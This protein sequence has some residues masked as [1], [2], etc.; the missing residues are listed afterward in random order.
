MRAGSPDRVSIHRAGALELSAHIFDSA[1]GEVEM[2]CA[3]FVSDNRFA[4]QA[5]RAA[6]F[7]DTEASACAAALRSR[8]LTAKEPTP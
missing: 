2:L 3:L 8:S 7:R 1:R 4:F 5:M 6:V